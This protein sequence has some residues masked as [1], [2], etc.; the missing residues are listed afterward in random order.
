MTWCPLLCYPLSPSPVNI[1]RFFKLGAKFCRKIYS[2]QALNCFLLLV[3]TASSFAT[4]QIDVSERV[5]M[6]EDDNLDDLDIGL[7]LED[8]LSSR[9]GRS[10]FAFPFQGS[11]SPTAPSSPAQ[12]QK[13]GIPGSWIPNFFWPKLGK[14]RQDQESWRRLGKLRQIRK[15]HPKDQESWR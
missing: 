5:P 10:P 7:G 1:E 4:G 15:V 11:P 13:S 6:F 8:L 3:H 9:M 14:L 12:S 2:S